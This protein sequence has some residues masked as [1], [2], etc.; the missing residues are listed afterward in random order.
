VKLNQFGD[1]ALDYEHE[2]VAGHP[3]RQ[4]DRLGVQRGR[5]QFPHRIALAWR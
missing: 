4:S 2:N 5:C 3:A 1:V